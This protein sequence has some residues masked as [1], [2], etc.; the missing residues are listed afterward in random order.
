MAEAM[1]Q[2]LVWVRLP[3]SDLERAKYRPAIIVSNNIYNKNGQDVVACGITSNLE[4]KDYSILIDQSNL[5]SG[6]LP[7]KS[8]IR[9]DKIMLLE[10][11]IIEKPFAKLDNRTFD[12]LAREIEKLIKRR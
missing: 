6:K 3:F 12:R 7:V 10:K 11:R 8:R 4:D 9:A 5:N 2:D 1:Q